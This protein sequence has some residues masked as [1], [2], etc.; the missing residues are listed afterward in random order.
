MIGGSTLSAAASCTYAGRAPAPA[1]TALTISYDAI[2]HAGVVAR[3]QVL[4][5]G[6]RRDGA[7]P[8]NRRIGRGEIDHERVAQRR[9]RRTSGRRARNVPSLNG[10][11][12]CAHGNRARGRCRRRRAAKI[13]RFIVAASSSGESYTPERRRPALVRVTTAQTARRRSAYHAKV[14]VEDDEIAD[15]ARHDRP[16]H[17]SAPAA[18]PA[19]SRTSRPRRRTERPNVLTMFRNARSIVSVLPGQRAVVEK[20]GRRRAT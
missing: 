2:A 19:S 5:V 6:R 16:A 13:R 17:R 8:A 1:P 14:A 12:A 10:V 7:S 20:R 4:H 15:S 9:C 18:A 3:D 11:G